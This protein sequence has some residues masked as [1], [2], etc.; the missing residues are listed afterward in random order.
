VNSRAPSPPHACLRPAAAP[1]H[2]QE[3]LLLSSPG[4]VGLISSGPRDSNVHGA[5]RAHPP[6]SSRARA[7]PSRRAVPPPCAQLCSPAPRAPPF[8]CTPCISLRI[9][10]PGRAQ[11]RWP[12]RPGPRAVGHWRAPRRSFSPSPTS[13]LSAPPPAVPGPAAEMAQCCTR[14]S[15][16]SSP[17]STS[18]GVLGSAPSALQPALKR[19]PAV[20]SRGRAHPPPPSHRA[21]AVRLPCSLPAEPNACCAPVLATSRSSAPD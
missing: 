10:R 2:P 1:H 4:Y 18:P 3:P 20:S 17:S 14:P 8:P 11:S 21:S 13:S 12:S 16:R 5:T 7:R 19:E 6:A 15:W 9:L